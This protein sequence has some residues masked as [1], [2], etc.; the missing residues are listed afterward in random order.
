MASKNKN[1]YSSWLA[2]NF[3]QVR[4]GGIFQESEERYAVYLSNKQDV[5]HRFFMQDDGDMKGCTTMEA[6]GGITIKCGQDKVREDAVFNIQIENGV[7]NITAQTGKI[8]IQGKD[9]TIEAKGNRDDKNPKGKDGVVTIKANSNIDLQAPKININGTQAMK[10]TSEQKL[11]LVSTG[12]MDM[13]GSQ[14]TCESASSNYGSRGKTQ[15]KKKLG[16]PEPPQ[17]T[18][19]EIQAD[20]SSREAQD[21]EDLEAQG[22]TTLR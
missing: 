13:Y 7:L 8:N 12:T 20:I 10:V 3:G 1:W 18:E 22:F 16:V 11:S 6:P 19:E 5:R 21:R 14:V 9:V 4:F 17:F 15:I 2:N